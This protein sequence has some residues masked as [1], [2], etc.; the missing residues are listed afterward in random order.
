MM[1]PMMNDLNSVQPVTTR[2]VGRDRHAFRRVIVD[3]QFLLNDLSLNEAAG[4]NAAVLL[5]NRA[6]NPDQVREIATERGLDEAQI[7]EML[8]AFEFLMNEY[9]LILRDVVSERKMLDKRRLG[10]EESA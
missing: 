9:L 4:M 8:A 3:L 5:V 7:E 6:A 1:N 10:M 2:L